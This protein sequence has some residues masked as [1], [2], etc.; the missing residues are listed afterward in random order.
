[1]CEEKRREKKYW[2]FGVRMDLPYFIVAIIGL[3]MFILGII[4]FILFIPLLIDVISLIIPLMGL[5]ISITSI[6]SSVTKNYLDVAVM[7]L[8]ERFNSLEHE[9]KKGFSTIEV[10][11]KEIRDEL[12]KAITKPT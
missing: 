6:L 4:L 10:L 12:Q 8:E 1:M 3:T 2:F 9:V 11:L 5:V 7:K